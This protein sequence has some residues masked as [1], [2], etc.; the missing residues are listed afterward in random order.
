MIV[1]HYLS[2]VPLAVHYQSEQVLLETKHWKHK[3]SKSDYKKPEVIEAQS[4]E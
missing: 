2:I 3:L 4:S 1:S